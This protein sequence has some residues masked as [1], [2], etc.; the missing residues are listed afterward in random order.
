MPMH[1]TINF[2]E[3]RRK[4]LVSQ[5]IDFYEKSLQNVTW[6]ATRSFLSSK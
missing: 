2:T 5:K 6:S 1:E 4:K 3:W